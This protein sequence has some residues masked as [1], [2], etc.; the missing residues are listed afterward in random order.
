MHNIFS[1]GEMSEIQWESRAI[2]R[3]SV[4]N[5]SYLLRVISMAK[6][7]DTRHDGTG[8]TQHDPPASIP[9][10]VQPEDPADREKRLRRW[11]EIAQLPKWQTMPLDEIEEIQLDWDVRR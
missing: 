1:V 11:A 3:Q 8:G 4:G 5:Y 9:P 10:P 6:N 7:D 2:P